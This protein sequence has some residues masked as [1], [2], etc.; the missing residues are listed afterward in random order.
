MMM[1]PKVTLDDQEML[2]SAYAYLSWN[3]T[4]FFPNLRSVQIQ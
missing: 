4:S 2:I 1:A 3:I